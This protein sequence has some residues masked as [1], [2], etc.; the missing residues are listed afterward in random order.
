MTTR[1]MPHP[2]YRAMTSAIAAIE[3]ERQRQHSKWGCQHHDPVYWVGILTE[4]L[5]EVAR[6]AIELRPF[7]ERGERTIE[8]STARLRAELVQL[9]AVAVAAIADLDLMPID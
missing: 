2:D 4:E 6:E 8:D 1:V 9:A 3:M 5:G 7:A